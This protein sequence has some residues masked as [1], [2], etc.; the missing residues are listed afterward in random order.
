MEF[1]DITMVRRALLRWDL[2]NY[3]CNEIAIDATELK[4]AM[5]CHTRLALCLRPACHLEEAL[6][7]HSLKSSLVLI[8]M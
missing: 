1:G 3:I 2:Q 6:R 4:P 5:K 8:P 7:N